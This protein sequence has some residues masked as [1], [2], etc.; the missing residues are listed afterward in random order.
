MSD[1]GEKLVSQ[2]N[3]LLPSPSTLEMCMLMR[4]RACRKGEGP[5]LGGRFVGDVH[6]YVVPLLHL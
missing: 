1:F 3:R 5:R 2:G 4:F 6:S